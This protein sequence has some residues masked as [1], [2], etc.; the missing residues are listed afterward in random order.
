M[1]IASFIV[2]SAILVSVEGLNWQIGIISLIIAVLATSL[3]AFSKLGID[4]FTVPLGSAICCF[5]CNQAFF[6]F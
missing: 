5:L 6:N 1:A 3:E 4:N 2:T